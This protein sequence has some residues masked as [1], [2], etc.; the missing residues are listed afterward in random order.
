MHWAALLSLAIW[1]YLALFHG[2][3]WQATERLRPAPPPAAWPDVAIVVPARNEADT[4]GAVVAAHM[5]TTYPGRAALFL[6]DDSSEDGTAAIARAAADGRRA[7]TVVSAP[8]LPPGWSG[9]LWALHHGIAA[10]QATMPAAS[11]LL[12]TDADIVHG[13]DLLERLVASAEADGLALVSVMARLDTRGAWGALLIPAF[14]YFFQKLY[15]FPRVNDPGSPVAGA[16]G[17]VV[18]VRAGALS[19]IGGIESIRSAL[20]DDC[21]LAARVKAGPPRRPIR[22]VLADAFASATSLRDNRS[23]RSVETMVKRTAYSQL[24]FSPLRLVGTVLGMVLVYLV[25]PAALLSWPLHGDAAAAAAGAC[26]WGLMALTF[27]PT[28]LDYGLSAWRALTLPVAGCLY[29]LFTIASARAHHAGR[30]GLWKGRT[31]A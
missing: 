31:Y 21:T 13:P 18:L 16:A 3:F 15:P 27:R 8:P 20:I 24:G 5:A 6:V 1:L 29:T 17:G 22:L 2:R 30:G 11:F 10:A 26:A 14:L 7:L 4:I 19:A 23:Y 9:K 12:L 28:L 25:P